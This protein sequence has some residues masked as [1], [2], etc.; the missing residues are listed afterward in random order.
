MIEAMRSDGNILGASQDWIRATYDHEYSYHFEWMGMPIIQYPQDI[1]AAQELIWTTQ[2]TVIIETGI[3]RGG[4]LVFYASMLQ[5]TGG[6]R[7]VGIDIDIRA[8]NRAAIEAHPMFEHIELIEGSSVDPAIVRRVEAAVGDDGPVMVVLDS[9]HTHDHVLDELRLYAPL[10]SKGCF[11]VVFDTIVEELPQS[12]FSN[13]PWGHGNSPLS[14]V[15]AYLAETDEFAVDESIC[16][17]LGITAARQGYLR[18][19]AG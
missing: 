4:S 5:M 8:H 7:V 12:A 15:E 17:K 10:V 18:R 13:R 16:A 3:A 1:V 2:P 9:N 14:A 19:V 6:G 11:L